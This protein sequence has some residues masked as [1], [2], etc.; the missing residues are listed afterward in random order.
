MNWN[1]S[2]KKAENLIHTTLSK[3]LQENHTIELQSLLDKCNQLTKHYTFHKNNKY[4]Q[5][6]KYIKYNFNGILE[7]IKEN[8]HYDIQNNNKQIYI[9]NILQITDFHDWIIL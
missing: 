3:I 4:N 9:V 5:F 7:F 1:S 6:S 8:T 2:K